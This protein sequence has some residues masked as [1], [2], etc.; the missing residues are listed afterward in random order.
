MEEQLPILSTQYLSGYHL[1]TPCRGPCSPCFSALLNFDLW[2]LVQSFSHQ[3]RL[4]WGGT[5]MIIFIFKSKR[6][7][8]VLLRGTFKSLAKGLCRHCEK[9][10]TRTPFFWIVHSF[11]ESKPARSTAPQLVIQPKSGFHWVHRIQRWFIIKTYLQVWQLSL[12][13]LSYWVDLR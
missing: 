12:W 1:H 11:F 6:I 9:R 4:F 8:K 3:A 5:F 2:L 7:M 13:A 10:G